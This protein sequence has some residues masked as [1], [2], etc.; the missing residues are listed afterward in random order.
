MIWVHLRNPAHIDQAS[1]NRLPAQP[2]ITLREV[3][4]ARWRRSPPVRMFSC[5]AAN[6]AAG[7]AGKERARMS[8]IQFFPACARRTGWS[9]R[10]I[11]LLSRSIICAVVVISI[12]TLFLRPEGLA[13]QILDSL[14]RTYLIFI[15]TVMAHEGVHGHLG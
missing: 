13:I 15:G 5:E 11:Y 3:S 4:Q 2:L 10:Q 9:R 6:D 1:A 8:A 14:F 7:D 12:G